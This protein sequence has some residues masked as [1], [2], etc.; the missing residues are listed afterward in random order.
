VPWALVLALNAGK[1]GELC[2]DIDWESD[3]L[4]KLGN[5][6]ALA[7]FGKKT[8][9]LLGGRHKFDLGKNPAD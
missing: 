8:S 2:A 6:T 7:N 3:V 4:E 1:P 5:I 9:T